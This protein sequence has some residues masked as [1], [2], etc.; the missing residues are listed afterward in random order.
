MIIKP[1]RAK[2]SQASQP[3][4]ANFGRP[5]IRDFNFGRPEI[6]DFSLLGGRTH[7]QKYSIAYIC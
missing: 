6:R 7:F 4:Q 2:P 1:S 5:E 3:K